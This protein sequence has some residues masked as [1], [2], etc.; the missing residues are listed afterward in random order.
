MS[1]RCLCGGNLI[2]GKLG[3][4]R[5]GYRCDRCDYQFQKKPIL[6]KGRRV[7]NQE[8]LNRRLNVDKNQSLSG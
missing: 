2:Y 8:L 3:P 5:M 4:G 1:K 6:P 7:A